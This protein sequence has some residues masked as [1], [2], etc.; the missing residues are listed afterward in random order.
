ML[1]N[2]L[3]NG[4]RHH[5]SLFCCKTTNVQLRTMRGQSQ[6]LAEYMV[7]VSSLSPCKS[8]TP[9]ATLFPCQEKDQIS[10]GGELCL[11]M[12]FG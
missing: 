4:G 6:R 10:C 12:W 8:V 2:L 11:S 9:S 3:D 1:Q 7:L 5:L